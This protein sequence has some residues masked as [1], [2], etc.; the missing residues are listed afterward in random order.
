MGGETW[1]DAA[2]A[3]S[4]ETGVTIQTRAIGPKRKYQDHV[5]D[6]ARASEVTDNGCVLVRPDHHAALRRKALTDDT[7]GD[8]AAALKSVLSL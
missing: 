2:E 3:L 4:A 8:L 1:I 6:W 7:A 5:G